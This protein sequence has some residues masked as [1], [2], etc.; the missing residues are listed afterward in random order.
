[1]YSKALRASEDKF[2]EIAVN[3]WDFIIDVSKAGCGSISLI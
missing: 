1:M 3:G 2:E